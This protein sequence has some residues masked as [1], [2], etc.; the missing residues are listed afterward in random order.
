MSHHV[1]TI[2]CYEIMIYNDICFTLVSCSPILRDSRLVP[3][4]HGRNPHHCEV[5]ERV[6]PPNSGSPR[7]SRNATFANPPSGVT[8]IILKHHIPK[9]QIHKWWT[10]KQ[11]EAECHHKYFHRILMNVA[12]NEFGSW[13]FWTAGGNQKTKPLTHQL[14]NGWPRLKDISI[15]MVS[16]HS[17]SCNMVSTPT[18]SILFSDLPL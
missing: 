1:I 2:I 10:P 18:S 12:R 6:A 14:C 8:L 16:L 4:K 7:A 15:L 3:Q 5:L 17:V 11:F 9:W 13:L